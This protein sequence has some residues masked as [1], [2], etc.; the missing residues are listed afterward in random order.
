M[1]EIKFYQKCDDPMKLEK[2]PSEQSVYSL[3]A[4]QMIVDIFVVM[5]N[6]EMKNEKSYDTCFKCTLGLIVN[7]K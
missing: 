5:R 4:C 7:V 6:D 3:S 1:S 2:Y